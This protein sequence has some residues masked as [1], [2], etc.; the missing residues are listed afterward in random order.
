[1]DTNLLGTIYSSQSLIKP[2]IRRKSGC[3]INISSVLGLRGVKGT[4][5]Y[6]AT[7]AGVIGFTKAL[8]VE[9]GSRNIRVNAI[10]P[11]LVDTDLASEVT[12]SL[13]ELY[14]SQSPTKQL[15]PPIEIANVALTLALSNHMNGSILTIDGGFTA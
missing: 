8:A 5:V 7:K 6:A 12:G 13:R 15:I 10:C 14:T 4:S 2:M 1:M 9:L 11:G 3:I